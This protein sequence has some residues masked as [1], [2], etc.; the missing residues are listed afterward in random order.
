MTSARDLKNLLSGGLDAIKREKGHGDC[1]GG[2]IDAELGP[3]C[4]CGTILQELGE[5]VLREPD[6]GVTEQAAEQAT[7]ATPLETDRRV[8]AAEKDATVGRMSRVDPADPIIAGLDVIDPTNP[9]TPAE[10]E[11]H[12]LDCMARLEAGAHFERLCIEERFQAQLAHD[13]AYARAIVAASSDRAAADTRKAK[14]VLETANEKTRLMVAD[15]QVKAVQSTMHSLRATLIGYCSVAK[16][17][18]ATYNTAGLTG[19]QF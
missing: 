15:M 6:S 2:F 9:Y 10:V 1:A 4:G 11:A 12:M 8:F 17:I 18:G 13:L 16:S 5:V 7:P 14:A 3:V 19:R